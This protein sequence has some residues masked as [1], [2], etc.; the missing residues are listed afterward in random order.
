MKYICLGYY[1]KGKFDALPEAERNAM[2]DACFEYD[3]HLRAN[4]YSAGG[5]ALQGP[6]N[7]LTLYWRNG[8]V[9]TSELIAHIVLCRRRC[10]LA[11]INSFMSAAGRIS[12]TLPYFSAGCCVM[13]CTA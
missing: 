1:D 12:K 4:G 11:F 5:E 8:K 7:A 13:S 2:F 3:D 6:E 10:S 9:A